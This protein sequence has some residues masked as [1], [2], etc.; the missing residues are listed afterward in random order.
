MAPVGARKGGPSP[1]FGGIKALAAGMPNLAAA[2]ALARL[3]CPAAVSRLW[4]LAMFLPIAKK[5]RRH[6]ARL[7]GRL[8]AK[9][10]AKNKRR[11]RR[12]ARREQ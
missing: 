7:G 11:H 10:K 1:G 4:T 2:S 5:S 12:L 3:A 9:F 8:K 6:G